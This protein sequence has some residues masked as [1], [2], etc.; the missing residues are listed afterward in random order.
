MTIF[1]QFYDSA[2]IIKETMGYCTVFDLAIMIGKS[3]KLS[4][5]HFNY[6][7]IFFWQKSSIA[8]VW[9]GSK[10][11][12]DLLDAL[13]KVAPLNSFVLQYLHHTQSVICFQKWK[14]FTE[15]ILIANFTRYTLI[16]RYHLHNVKWENQ[17][18]QSMKKTLT[19]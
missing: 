9:L 13:S 11:A 17:K 12:S 6:C 3:S 8:D 2:P 4:R 19:Q 16:C 10:Y 7:I 14:H 15:K 18:V 5:K 1:S